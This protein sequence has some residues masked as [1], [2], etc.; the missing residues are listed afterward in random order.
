MKYL[1]KMV[2]DLSAYIYGYMFAIGIQV[3]ECIMANYDSN[4]WS[5]NDECIGG[6]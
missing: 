3:P 1:W 2:V 6:I 5:G 4:Y